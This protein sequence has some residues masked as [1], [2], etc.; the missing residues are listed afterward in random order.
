MSASPPI[1]TVAIV[2][3]GVV[4][5]M[6][7]LALTRTLPH[8]RVELVTMPV[9]AEALAD[10]LPRLWPSAFP[11]LPSLGLAEADLL[12]R[13]IA[14]PLLARRFTGWSRSG[15]RWMCPEGETVRIP[16][17]GAL[18]QR[19][20]HAGARMAFHD[21]FPA[22][23][24]A[25]AG[26]F[27]PDALV[28]TELAQADV[29]LAL[30]PDRFGAVIGAGCQR[31]NVV[32]SEGPLQAALPGPDGGWRAI[33]LASGRVIEADL[34]V[35]AAGKPLPGEEWLDWS[36]VLP[37]DRLTVTRTDA[38]GLVDEYETVGDGWRAR[39]AHGDT[40][41]GAVAFNAGIGQAKPVS[42]A[43]E[44]L[45]LTPGA[46]AYGWT[47]NLLRLGDGAAQ[48]G[49]LALPG[50]T[51]AAHHLLLA[52]ELL[53]ARDM[54]PVLVAE[55]NRRARLRTEHLRDFVAA[56]YLAGGRRRGPFWTGLSAVEPPSSLADTLAQFRRRGQLPHRDED[57]VPADAWRAVLLGQ[58]IRPAVPDPVVLGTDRNVE[59]QTLMSACRSLAMQ[60]AQFP[61]GAPAPGISF[62]RVPK[63]HTAQD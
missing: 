26:R 3:S 25:E 40:G 39:W 38:S 24:L 32:V 35:W 31:A 44:P 41:I 6:A 9:P 49:A 15:G 61:D 51:L 5:G 18:H 47:G 21:L 27:S 4:A 60:A 42:D 14:A 54:E 1:R 29:T 43:A 48:L 13:G 59:R 11:L 55:Y 58:G 46:A 22:A 37:A 45:K 17:T 52:L 8:A 63:P 53:P 7:A 30:A 56:H 36:G 33:R 57:S 62:V 20:L 10:R 23:A 28:S 19:W 12:A 16:G 50:F 34:F 2:G